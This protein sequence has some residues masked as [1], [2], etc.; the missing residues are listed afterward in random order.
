MDTVMATGIAALD[1]NHEIRRFS[2]RA[3]PSMTMAR[4]IAMAGGVRMSA[5]Q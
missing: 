1:G 3:K 2:T 4:N 5:S